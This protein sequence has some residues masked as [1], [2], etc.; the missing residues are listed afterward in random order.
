MF[1]GA[2]VIVIVGTLVFNY[3][4]AGKGEN[5]TGLSTDSVAPGEHLVVKGETL[6][7][8]AEN[9]YGSGYNWTDIKLANNLNSDKI[10]VEQKLTLP[11]VAVKN[12]TT[13]VK[14]SAEENANPIASDSYTIVKGDNL[15]ESNIPESFNV[16]IRELQGLGL[17]MKIE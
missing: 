14:I 9:A 6:W 5:L 7:G 10:E 12:P 16:L 13:T 17:E 8:I 4:K 3:Y 1:L 15:P 2:L 11:E